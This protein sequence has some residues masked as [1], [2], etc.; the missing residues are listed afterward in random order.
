MYIYI[1]KGRERWRKRGPNNVEITTL[2]VLQEYVSVY[3]LVGIGVAKD[4]SDYRLKWVRI[5]MA[6][7]PNTSWPKFRVLKIASVLIQKL[8]LQIAFSIFFNKGKRSS[9][10]Y[11]Q[12][13]LEFLDSEAREKRKTY[14][15]VKRIAYNE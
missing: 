10:N 13:S 5:E 6:M 11:C 7:G 1:G 8:C 9:R 3:K 4:R 2:V 14:Y 15:H 12:S